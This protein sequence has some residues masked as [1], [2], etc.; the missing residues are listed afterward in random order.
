MMNLKKILISGILM[1]LPLAVGLTG[2]A[3]SVTEEEGEEAQIQ[4]QVEEQEGSPS[5]VV[6]PNQAGQEELLNLPHLDAALVEGILQRR[7][8]LSMTELTAFLSESLGEEQRAE[9]YV[10]LFVPMNLN[11]T[12]EE[13]FLL[14]PGVGS[15]LAHEFEEY[16]PYQAMAQFRREIG[17]YVDEEEVARLEQYVFVPVNLNTASDEE[18]L[19]IPGVGP[20]LLHEFKEYRPYDSIEQFRREIGK[21]VS[22]EEVSRLERYVTL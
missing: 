6:N 19:T 20:R 12:A 21:Y 5:A 14:V 9:L 10:Q 22:E 8:F 1:G 7:P 18:I 16:R 4:S 17:K 13:D 2:C 11:T 15:R 3:G